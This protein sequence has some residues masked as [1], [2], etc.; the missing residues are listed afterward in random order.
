MVG[1][2]LA[3]EAA[4]VTGTIGNPVGSGEKS[5]VISVSV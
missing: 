1:G 2:H 3:G 5:G 4:I